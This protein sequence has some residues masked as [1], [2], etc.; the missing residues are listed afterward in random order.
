MQLDSKKSNDARS[1]SN[2]QESQMQLTQTQREEHSDDVNFLKQSLPCLPY[3]A[4]KPICTSP[5][6][7]RTQISPQVYVNAN[8]FF[9]VDILGLASSQVLKTNNN[10]STT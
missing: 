2:L 1:P 3:P 6:T 8:A 4:P 9:E 7:H 5:S 10:P